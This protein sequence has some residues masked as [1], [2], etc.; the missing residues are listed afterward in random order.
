MSE[1]FTSKRD[2]IIAL[3]VQLNRMWK[4][5]WLRNV[6]KLQPHK[7]LSVIATAQQVQIFNGSELRLRPSISVSFIVA[8]SFKLESEIC[9]SVFLIS[10]L[11]ATRASRSKGSTRN[12]VIPAP[13]WKASITN[14]GF[15]S[16]FLPADWDPLLT[17]EEN[18]SNLHPQRS[19][20]AISR[21]IPQKMNVFGVTEK[22]V[23]G[24]HGERSCLIYH[25]PFRL[26]PGFWSLSEIY[27]LKISSGAI[28]SLP[29]VSPSER[30]EDKSE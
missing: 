11:F 9:F 30:Q 27:I 1:A 14:F 28:T 12:W 3:A 21:N 29:K 20:L 26:P 2:D 24:F 10:K 18:F 23:S 16:T 22:K 8:N 17:R 4:N 19:H 6:I 13:K 7:G 5:L 25:P 15:L